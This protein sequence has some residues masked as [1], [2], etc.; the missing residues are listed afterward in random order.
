MDSLFFGRLDY[1][2]K[3][4]RLQAKE[5]EMVWMGS[6]NLDYYIL[7]LSISMLNSKRNITTLLLVL[8]IFCSGDQSA[9]FSG[10]NYNGYSGPNGFCFDADCPDEPIKVTNNLTA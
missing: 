4:K 10:V 9:L 2:D 1:Q 3:D 8:V 7:C 6:D 5:M